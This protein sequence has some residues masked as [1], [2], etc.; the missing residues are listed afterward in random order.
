MRISPALLM[1]AAWLV[2]VPAYAE[3][4]AVQPSR[5][6]ARAPEPKYESVF[7]S[8]VP[9]RETQPA[10][11]REVNDEVGRIGGHVGMF[12]AHGASKPEPLKPQAGAPA[13][14][15]QGAAAQTPSRGEPKAPPSHPMTQ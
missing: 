15:A 3:S 8:Y 1:Y 5:R 7:R 13:S 14:A 11:W 12:R 6:D 2:V 4:K 10:P 9:Y